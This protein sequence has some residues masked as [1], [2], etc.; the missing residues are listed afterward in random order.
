MKVKVKSFLNMPDCFFYYK[1][2]TG[3]EITELLRRRAPTDN[4]YFLFDKNQKNGL[5]ECFGPFYYNQKH[6]RVYDYNFQKWL[7]D[8]WREKM[9][10]KRRGCSILELEEFLEFACKAF[11]FKYLL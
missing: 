10:H 6:I 2:V 8:L 4:L 9:E 1:D 3:S 5:S 7:L 11:K